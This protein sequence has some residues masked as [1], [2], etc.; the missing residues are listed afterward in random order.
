MQKRRTFPLKSFVLGAITFLAVGASACTIVFAS[1]NCRVLAGGNEDHDNK[2]KFA[3]HYIR[4]QPA[5]PEKMALGYVAFGYKTNPF[6]DES[7]MNEAG[8]FYD[9]NALDT[10]ETPREGKP[11]GKFSTISQMLTTCKTVA[12]A[13]TFLESV[14][15]SHMSSAQIL[16][17]DATGASAI[18]ERHATTWRAKNRDFQIGTNFRTSATPEPKIT[19]DRYKRCNTTLS[20]NQP[21]TI[22]GMAS[23]LSNTTANIPQTITW[24]SLICDL[25]NKD[26]YL[27]IKGDFTK[28]IHL[29]LPAELKKGARRLDMEELVTNSSKHVDLTKS[30]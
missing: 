24:Y 19:C 1:R 22:P 16:I 12:E 7:A 29:N 2:P 25:K 21:I 10:L 23:I 8:L 13:V 27:S 9:F 11:K 28:T 5:I 4:F 18:L 6:S 17:G 20:A 30:N 15:L 26:V 14:G 3:S